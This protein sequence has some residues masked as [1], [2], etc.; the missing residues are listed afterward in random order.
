MTMLPEKT[1]SRLSLFR[2]VLLAT[3]PNPTDHHVFSHELAMLADSNPAQVRRD[4]MTIGFSGSPR[5]GYHVA[6]LLASLDAVLDAPTGQNV[7]LVGVG[8]LGRAV[9]S[10]FPGRLPK[11]S[12]VAAFDS[13]PMKMDRVIYGCRVHSIDRLEEV[14]SREQISVG[15]ITVPAPAAQDVARRLARAGVLGLLNFAPA[16]LNL[17]AGVYFENV[18][19]AAALDKTAY[20]ARILALNRDAMQR[21]KT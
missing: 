15:I 10:Y 11:L 14:V 20:F 9:L 13:D 3:F 8:Q 12:I 16:P 2:R 7:A 18:D 5:K 17:P 1:L 6:R 19:M 4:L 21:E